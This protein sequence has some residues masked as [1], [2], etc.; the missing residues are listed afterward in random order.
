MRSG[1]FLV[2]LTQPHNLQK[3]SAQCDELMTRLSTISVDNLHKKDFPLSLGLFIG[4]QDSVDAGLSDANP[5]V[6][7]LNPS[8]AAY[9]KLPAAI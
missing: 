1:Q 3:V 7:Y 6:P 4:R 9:E 2:N 8:P 5:P